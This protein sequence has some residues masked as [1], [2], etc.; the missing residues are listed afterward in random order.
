[1][2]L[3]V[4]DFRAFFSAVHSTSP[5]RSVDPFPWQQRLVEQVAET[6]RWPQLLDLPTGAGKTAAID[7]AVFLA[8]LRDDMPRRIVFVVDRRVIVAQAYQHAQHLLDALAEPDAA[9][10]IAKVRDALATRIASAHPVNPPLVAAEL[11]GGI[12]RDESWALRPDVPAI[13]T[14][15]IDQVGSRLLFRGYGVSRGMRPVHAGLLG[16][17]ALFLLDEVHL[18]RPFAQTLRRID[19]NYIAP[20]DSVDTPRWQVVELSATPASQAE[21]HFTL[22]SADLD[23]ERSPLLHQRYH[24]GKPA[25]CE[26]VKV[27]GKSELSHGEK[28][29]R[30]AVSEARALLGTDTAR[31]VGVI[32]NRVHTARLAALE[33]AS[34]ADEVA[35]MTGRMRPL[36]RDRL[37]RE[38]RDRLATGHARDPRSPRRV[39]VATQAIEA[40]ADFDLDAIV[41][42]CAPYDALVQ[43]FG[44][45][46]RNGDMWKAG[47]TATSVVLATSTQ[48]KTDDPIYGNALRNTW[49]W[50]TQRDVDFGI[51]ARKGDGPVPVD[52][53]V[54]P[55]NAPLLTS[56][57]LDRW[58]QTSPIPD[59]DADP[60]LWLHGMLERQPE[61]EI[62]VVWRADVDER[63]FDPILLE[64]AEPSIVDAL[65]DIVAATPPTSLEAL[66]IPR[67]AA[68]RWITARGTSAAEFPVADVEADIA[69]DAASDEATVKVFAWRGETDSTM[70]DPK[71]LRPGDT[72]IVPATWGGLALGNWAPDATD[73]VTDLAQQT[74]RIRRNL[75]VFRLTSTRNSTEVDLPDFETIDPS[76]WTDEVLARAREVTGSGAESV[77]ASELRDAF[78]VDNRPHVQVIP[79]PTLD[80]TEYVAVLTFRWT[81]PDAP[82]RGSEHEAATDTADSEPETSSFTGRAVRL[83]D[84]LNDVRDWADAFGRACGLRDPVAA[85]VALAGAFHDLG[86][87]DPRFQELLRG[88]RPGQDGVLLAKSAM[89]PTDRRARIDARLAAKYPRGMRHE[90]LSVALAES[91]ELL[92]RANDRDLVLHLVAS[93]HGH[94]RPLAPAIEEP[95]PQDV[96]LEL[97][98]SILG[99]TSDHRLASMD[100]PLADRFHAL[101]GRYGW[102]GLAWLEAILRLADHRASATP[103]GPVRD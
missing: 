31:T 64:R 68:R 79:Y 95:D 82:T 6:G 55:P 52:L 21:D 5:G 41:T 48:V 93:H 58:V 42:E 9:P 59:A 84:H 65:T 72:I 1:M 23:P 98:G 15:T 71:D 102:W 51:A 26:L 88:G 17:D 70:V 61:P 7:I 18:A 57:H 14:S 39:V 67:S 25:R 74:Q 28:L 16:R 36:D 97:E 30:Q 94:A 66:G 32:V 33:A 85:D 3:A 50:M 96:S 10:P 83:V 75:N 4:T 2:T 47:G 63:L 38:W 78:S 12:V 19:A 80:G 56:V 35:L 101:V 40:G 13:L 22:T 99:A 43:R 24:A 73:T 92:D 54:Q 34:I 103:G 8:A 89:S 45:V 86:K 76:D 81:P 69:H 44:R 77:L 60:A 87:A 46:D 20:Q 53:T 29:A 49:D 90:M 37:L 91:S 100:S 62:N 11:R 27:A